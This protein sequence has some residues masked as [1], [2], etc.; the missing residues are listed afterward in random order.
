M[1]S[2]ELQYCEENSG[3]HPYQTRYPTLVHRYIQLLMSSA[4]L[5]LSLIFFVLIGIPGIE[6]SV[7]SRS[8]KTN[9]AGINRIVSTQKRQLSV[10]SGPFSLLVRE[11]ADFVF[12]SFN[13]DI[14][15]LNAMQLQPVAEKNKATVKAVSNPPNIIFIMVES[16]RPDVLSQYGAD[17]VITVSYT[18]LT[19][20]TICS[21]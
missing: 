7:A 5:S 12:S 9:D 6:S 10:K 13:T 8:N 11:A 14:A 1:V 4:F 15:V 17:Q 3:C 19:L 21:V 18:H 16:M 20:P 2:R